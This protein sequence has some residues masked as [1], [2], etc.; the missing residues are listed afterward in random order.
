M[1]ELDRTYEVLAQD[2][3]HLFRANDANVRLQPDSVL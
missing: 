1:P 3:N 2:W